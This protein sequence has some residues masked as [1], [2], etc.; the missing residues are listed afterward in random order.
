MNAHCPCTMVRHVDG[1]S[2]ARDTGVCPACWHLQS[3]TAQC[4]C[5]QTIRRAA[6]VARNR[7]E[8]LDYVLPQGEYRFHSN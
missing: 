2:H 1:E 8:F 6:V 3:H 7:A 5:N 4:D